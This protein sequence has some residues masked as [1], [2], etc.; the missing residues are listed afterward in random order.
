MKMLQSIVLKKRIAKAMCITLTLG[1]ISIQPNVSFA[2]TSDAVVCVSTESYDLV[3]DEQG[4]INMALNQ[5]KTTMS[6]TNSI[7]QDTMKAV[8]N[9]DDN[10]LTVVQLVNES[11]YSDG[12][13]EKAY[14]V[15]NFALENKVT[16][17]IS[18]SSSTTSTNTTKYSIAARQ[19]LYFTCKYYESGVVGVYNDILVH[20]TK[21]ESYVNF[22]STAVAY[23][24]HGIIA[25]AFLNTS[26]YPEVYN[27]QT[28][29]APV[30][31]KSYYVYANESN[32]YKSD[33]NGMYSS[34][35]N[36]RTSNNNEFELQID[37]LSIVDG[38]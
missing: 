34:I 24:K 6:I 35:M 30:N 37:I 2:Q 23:F 14:V 4:L 5:T 18:Y 32:Y 27:I 25:T 31:N 3:T 15:D 10:G 16:G 20:A 22:S 19:T 21:V 7:T 8:D 28:V 33:S 12:S 29:G 38:I 36:V 13:I 11:Y 26:V 1:I 17:S 9:S